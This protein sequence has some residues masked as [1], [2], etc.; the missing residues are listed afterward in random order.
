M[1]PLAL[2]ILLGGCNAFVGSLRIDVLT[3]LVPG[4]E[5]DRAEVILGGLGNA[6]R[7]WHD[8][9]EWETGARVAHYRDIEM[10]TYEGVVRLSL[11]G[12]TVLSRPVVITINDDL[13]RK[14]ILD[15]SCVG[16]ECPS[17]GGSPAA[18]ACLGGRCVDP[19][20][21]DGRQDACPEPLCDP[22]SDCTGGAICAV[23][24]CS[25]GGVCLYRNGC[26]PGEFCSVDTGACEPT[27]IPVTIDVV[28]ES[29]I[30]AVVPGE[31]DN[32]GWW[33]TLSEDGST[34][35]VAAYGEDGGSRTI[36]GD[37]NDDSL[38]GSGAVYVFTRTGD[39]W[40]QEAYLKASNGDEFDSF[41]SS[42]ALSAD[43]NVLAV[44]ADGEDSNA[45]GV[46]GDATNNDGATNGAVY[47]FRR[48]AGVWSEQAYLKGRWT[49]TY[50]FGD[51]LA[52]SGDGLVLA[53]GASLEDSDARGIGGDPANA[54]ASSSGAVFTFRDV[55]GTWVE[56]EYIKSSNSEASD[57][58]GGSL[59]LN[60]DGSVLV[61]GAYGEDGL[62]GDPA[63]NSG[64]YVG[65]AYVFRRT[66]DVWVEEAYVKAS[67]AEDSDAFGTSIAIDDSGMVFVVG[68]DGEDA[69]ELDET[70][71]S[72]P[73]AGAAYVFRFD[74]AAWV[75]TA[76]VKA[77]ERQA[78]DGFG[79]RVALSR[80]GLMLAVASLSD[81][82]GPEFVPGS[83]EP[84]DVRQVNSGA[85]Y[86]YRYSGI[87]WSGLGFVK[88]FNADTDDLFGRCA[89]DGDGDTLVVGATQEQSAEG[90]ID[91][92]SD[93]RSFDSGA[94][95]TYTLRY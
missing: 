74:G 72:S 55:G 14:I 12:A 45:T 59:A 36:N 38:E 37:E 64:D 18:I 93:N 44:G 95:Y 68:A 46:N 51:T 30:K 6:T 39:T 48:T 53:V 73:S 57:Y 69:G 91:P 63:D 11:N 83:G 70:D 66:G 60:R 24:T 3:D 32:F 92:D 31:E 71:N 82:S 47:V 49:E 88:A 80:D 7:F 23:A 43:G 62:S 86:V 13:A 56:D 29:F 67:N 4:V 22:D 52:I 9:Q 1:R 87:S 65:A 16:V 78:G 89:L 76:Y 17:A 25:G 81:D 40:I 94:V 85:V 26:A 19:V 28:A 84:F 2:L 41:G 33:T 75:Q 42:I 79:S 21:I 77:I 50:G 58:F 90:G 15:R 35:A 54:N 5:F 10:G 27:P 20:C 61:V 8:S 34:L